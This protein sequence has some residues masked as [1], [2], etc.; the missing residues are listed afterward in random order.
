MKHFTGLTTKEE[1]RQRYRELAKQH[2]PDRGGDGEIM[3]QINSEYDFLMAKILRGENLNTDE[4]NSQWESSEQ[5]KEKINLI[6]NLSGIEIEV[7]GEWI[8]VTGGT[9]AVRAELK[10]AGYYFASKKCAWFWRPEH[11]A[12]GRGKLDLEGIRTKYGSEKIITG[13]QLRKSIAA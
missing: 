7:C 1:V 11:A 13:G 10:S 6:I 3:K 2:H 5:F 12:G 4:F 9:Y 8:W